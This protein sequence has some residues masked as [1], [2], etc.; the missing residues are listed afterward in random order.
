MSSAAG[1]Y[2][3]RAYLFVDDHPYYTPTDTQ[4]HFVLD[5]VPPGHYEVVCWLPNWREAQHERDPDTAIIN[6]LLFH[7]PAE[8]VQPVAARARETAELHFQVSRKSFLP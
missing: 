5:R 8:M 3:M 1:R 6:R 2:A 7:K 4:G